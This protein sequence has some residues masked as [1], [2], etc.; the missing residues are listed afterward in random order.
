LF[1]RARARETHHAARSAVI[2]AVRGTS[3][4]GV[5][6]PSKSLHPKYRRVRARQVRSRGSTQALGRHDRSAWRATLVVAAVHLSHCRLQRRSPW[7]RL[8]SAPANASPHSTAAP[9]PLRSEGAAWACP[10]RDSNANPSQC[11]HDVRGSDNVT[12]VP[13]STSKGRT[14]LRRRCP[15]PRYYT[16]GGAAAGPLAR[17]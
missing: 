1:A 14:R 15:H 7:A 3:P 6:V 17:P 16:R 10:R 12:S 11:G 2:K 13:S 9:L 5:V 4:A 8:C